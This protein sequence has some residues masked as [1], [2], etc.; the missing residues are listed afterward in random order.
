M[1]SRKKP[2][3][4]AQGK[5]R[6]TE[7]PGSRLNAHLLPSLGDVPVTTWRV[8]HSRTVM[9]Q[10]AGTIFSARGREDLRGPVASMR[11]VARRLGRL[12]RSIDP[13]D[14]WETGTASVLRGATALHV[15]PRLRPGN[16]QVTAMGTLPTRHAA[17]NPPTH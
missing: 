6:T 11:T 15:D 13:L 7:Q 1:A 8:Q 2:W 4:L 16:R 10:G 17:P 14:G 12:D 9:E 5:P 3:L